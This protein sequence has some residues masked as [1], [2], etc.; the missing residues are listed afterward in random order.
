M[1]GARQLVLA[2]EEIECLDRLWRAAS[3]SGD[4]GRA[5]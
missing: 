1:L 4:P 5:G 2:G 3:W